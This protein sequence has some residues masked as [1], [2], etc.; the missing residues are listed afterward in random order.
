MNVPK[1]SQRTEA[2]KLRRK[3]AEESRELAQT[4]LKTANIETLRAVADALLTK[5]SR[6]FLDNAM[7]KFT[8]KE[9]AFISN[10]ACARRIR[11]RAAKL[12]LLKEPQELRESWTAKCESVSVETL[13][14]ML[15]GDVPDRV[16][17]TDILRRRLHEQLNRAVTDQLVKYSRDRTFPLRAEIASDV[18]VGR[19]SSPSSGGYE[20]WRDM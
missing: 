5:I 9:L 3:Q 4:V 15:T 6:R 12:A 18:L 10:N 2:N 14:L 17:A 19:P 13:A 11:E 8:S 7:S 1:T 16:I 20:N